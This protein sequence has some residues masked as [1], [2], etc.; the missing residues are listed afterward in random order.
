MPRRGTVFCL[1][2]FGGTTAAFAEVPAP[3]GF[4]KVAVPLFGHGAD[5]GSVRSFDDEAARLVERCRETVEPRIL[6]G[7]SLGGRLAL[8]IAQ[9]EPSAFTAAV[10][11]GANPGIEEGERAARA[12]KDDE[13]AALLDQVGIGPFF[14]HWMEQPLF[15]T[16]R[17]LAT[18]VLDKQ[19]RERESLK[20]G[21]LADAMRVLSVARMPDMWRSSVLPPVFYAAGELDPSYVAVGR[22]LV[23]NDPRFRLRIAAG[24]GHNLLLEAPSFV[25]AV[26]EEAGQT[27]PTKD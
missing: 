27:A 24:A 20:P 2:G 17:E 3:T 12:K 19:R 23:A 4:E 26:L 14:E 25:G 11:I 21:P 9:L 1:H 22:R 5:A 10:L 8:R 15:R 16:Q 18:V 6:C 13:W 7:Y